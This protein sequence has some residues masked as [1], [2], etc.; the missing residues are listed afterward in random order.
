MLKELLAKYK[1]KKLL[2]LNQFV[3]RKGTTLEDIKAYTKLLA[4]KPRRQDC[5][6]YDDDGNRILNHK[7]LF[8][9][10]QLCTDTSADVNKVAKLQTNGNS[11]KIYFMTAN[12]VTII[13]LENMAD[14]VTYNEL[15]IFFEGNLELN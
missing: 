14:E 1:S 11:Y 10:W 12:G 9:G 6:G 5:I 15:A 7:P 3:N 2:T 8:K 13:S 4:G